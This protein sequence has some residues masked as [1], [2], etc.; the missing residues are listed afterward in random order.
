MMIKNIV[1]I[2]IILIFDILKIMIIGNSK[3]I[4]TSK[5]R[6]ITAIK[7]NCNLKG[8]RAESIGSKPH[9]KGELFSRSINVFFD[10]ILATDIMIIVKVKII[11]LIIDVIKIIYT[12]K[13]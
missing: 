10:K 11:S 1:K 2:S 5:I 13:N 3:A 6:K 7:K 12:K 9:S 8:S 4:S